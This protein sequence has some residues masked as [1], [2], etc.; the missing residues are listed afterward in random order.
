MAWYYS[1]MARLAPVNKPWIGSVFCDGLDS[2]LPAVAQCLAYAWD[3]KSCSNNLL[4]LAITKAWASGLEQLKSCRLRPSRTSG[5]AKCG[6]LRIVSCLTV[7]Q[8]TVFILPTPMQ[9][10]SGA[11]IKQLKPWRRHKFPGLVTE[12]T[13]SLP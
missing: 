9:Y 2:E 5:G 12:E 6:Q 8:T 4:N 3:T 7:W 1:A 13:L 11:L 10:W